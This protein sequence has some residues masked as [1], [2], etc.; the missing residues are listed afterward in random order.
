MDIHE[1]SKFFK[2]LITETEDRSE[3]K[4]YKKFIIILSQLNNKNL[5]ELQ[6]HVIE[7]KLDTI[8]TEIPRESRKKYYRKKLNEFLSFLK[9]EFSLISESYYMTICMSL[10]M[11]FGMSIGMTFGVAFGG[12]QGLVYG[13]TFGLMIGMSIGLAIGAAMDINAKKEGKVLSVKHT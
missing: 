7:D 1:A 4:M 10:G 9:K 2:N 12:S 8:S 6:I 3:I 11:C 5:S 13:M